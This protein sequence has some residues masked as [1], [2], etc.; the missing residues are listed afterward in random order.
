MTII[1]QAFEFGPH[2]ATGN[3]LAE[4]A[5]WQCV[6]N[7]VGINGRAARGRLEAMAVM[8]DG[9]RAATLNI[10]KQ[11]IGNVFGVFGNPQ[12]RKWADEGFD[13][14]ARADLDIVGAF[15]DFDALPGWGE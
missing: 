11:A 1:K 6:L 3:Q 7:V 5:E 12:A 14:H 15:D 4:P 2:E 13:H 9:E 8:P 10:Y